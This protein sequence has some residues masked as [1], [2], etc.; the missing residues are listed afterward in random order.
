MHRVFEKQSSTIGHKHTGFNACRQR[1][2]HGPYINAAVRGFPHCRKMDLWGSSLSCARISR[3]F[4][5]IPLAPDDG[6]DSSKPVLSSRQSRDLQ[7]GFHSC[8]YDLNDYSGEFAVIRDFGEHNFRAAWQP[9]C[10]PS[11]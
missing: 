11:W 10:V 8:L 3:A 5:S 7:K 1:Y 6:H 2:H 9:I 4:F